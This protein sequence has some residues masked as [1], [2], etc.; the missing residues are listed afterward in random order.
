MIAE[1][2]I[3]EEIGVLLKHEVAKK[4]NSKISIGK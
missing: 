2:S 4:R 1:S 3:H